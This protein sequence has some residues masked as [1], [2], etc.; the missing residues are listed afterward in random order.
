VKSVEASLAARYDKYE[1]GFGTSF[2]N[3]SPKAGLSWRPDA[4]TMVRLSTARGFR[5][6]T[7]YDN[8]LPYAVNNTSANFSD[9]I[10]CPNGVPVKNTANP[11]GEFQ[12]EC[13]VQLNTRN[14]GNKN[15]EPEKS[16]QYSLGVVFQPTASFSGSID[17]W[18][19]KI[20]K[21]IQPM[22]EITVMGDPVRYAANY[23]RFDPRTDPD[24]KH[25]VISASPD[26]PLAFIDLPRVNSGKFYASGF[27]FNLNF[28]KKSDF[29]T[30][31]ANLDSTLYATHGYQYQGEEQV[32]DLGKYKDFGPVPRYRQALTFTW[33]M[34]AWNAS[35]THNFSDSY[36]DYTDEA[37]V[38]G[39]N[40]PALRKVAAYKTIDMTVGWKAP[41]TWM[42][43]KSLS[44]TF[45]IKNLLDQ[46]PPSSRT[47][48]NF[49]TGYDATFT[50]PLGRTFYFRVNYKFM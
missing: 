26:L 24:A 25:P 9:P 38:G 18:N 22:S 32:S 35:V 11:V 5:A 37:K 17:Y 46:D 47:E 10:R 40:Y 15:L 45:G 33:A 13:A 1:N 28:R 7:L 34:G 8:L 19:V 44:A 48:A 6:P 23:Y 36:D 20:D 49:Q 39:T 41:V 30:W 27:D 12:D 14:G 4:T 50:N 2:H 43:A 21:A 42:Y 31:G 16:K 29:G 3:L